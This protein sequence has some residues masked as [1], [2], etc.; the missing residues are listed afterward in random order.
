M[1]KKISIILLTLTFIACVK[2]PTE[3]TNAP[4]KFESSGVYILCEGLWGM[5]NASLSRYSFL[6]DNIYNNLYE[7]VNNG[8]K[9]GDLANDLVTYKGKGYI[10]VSTSK[11]IEVFD[12]TTCINKGRIIFED[13]GEPRKI[14]II[15]DSTAY[16]T[17]LSSHSITKFNP[18]TLDVTSNK[19]I[20]G[21][22][23]E[24]IT[25]FDNRVLVV[26]SGYGDYLANAPKASTISVI[27][28][29]SDLEIATIQTGT[30][31]IEILYNRNR[32]AFY[33]AYLNLPSLREKYDSLGG[34]IEYDADSY[35][36][37]RHWRCNPRSLILSQNGDSLLFL[38]DNTITLIKLNVSNAHKKPIITNPNVNEIWYCINYHSSDGSI[39]IGNAKNYVVAGELIIYKSILDLNNY[40][41]YP[42]GVNPNK[43]VFYRI[44]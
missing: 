5:N 1:N 31:P 7:K 27:D 19:I 23:P 13:K 28:I 37:L 10:S 36:I 14:I 42:V 29:N 25:S 21:P 6:E 44:E 17:R 20:V 11:T 24:G 35:Q 15:N 32:N 38:D 43:I 16:V 18:T 34:I 12:L 4:P 9:L 33:V 2:E 8:L 3:P 30:N 26:N 22:A 40:R 41:K 39:W